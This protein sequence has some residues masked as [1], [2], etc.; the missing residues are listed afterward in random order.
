LS[1]FLLFIL[2]NTI[3]CKHNNMEENQHTTSFW[4]YLYIV[5]IVLVIII[6]A[7][8]LV[9]GFA[10]GETQAK[11]AEAEALTESRKEVTLVSPEQKEEAQPIILTT[12]INE[13]VEVTSGCWPSLNETCIV[14]YNK[15]NALQGIPQQQ[16]RKGTILKSKRTF[17]END[18][19]WH[20]ITF[21]DE[22]IRY[23]ERKKGTW[24]VQANNVRLL[25]IEG[26]IEFD[27]SLITDPVASST[28]P[29]PDKLI[30][31]DRSDQKLYAYEGDV[32]FTEETI[33]TG[34]NYTPTPRGTFRIFKKIPSRYMQGPLPGISEKYY[35]LPGVPW[36][37]Y[38]TEQGGAIHG[39]YW[40]D[41][42]GTQW[43]SGCVN[44]PLDRM[45]RIYRWADIG[46]T[47]VVR[48]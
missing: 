30:I 35:D 11:Q 22:W 3:E 25:T 5:N 46:T 7:V 33:S 19:N 42:F 1:G 18:E 40:H 13:Y 32:L 48:D 23:P 24:Y 47:V 15:P 41:G 29:T 45:E 36:N 20:E 12:T 37:M 17:F 44:V 6:T 9:R 39:A 43:S 10:S 34:L 31:V 4:N 21:E 8:L 2:I 14:A 28:I 27:P 16:L 26:L 38:F